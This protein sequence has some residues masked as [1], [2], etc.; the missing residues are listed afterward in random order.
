MSRYQ[1]LRPRRHLRVL[2]VAGLLGALLATA[3]VATN[4]LGVGTRFENLVRRIEIA[5]DPPPDRPSV[6][7]V[8]VTPRPTLS[9]TPPATPSDAPTAPTTSSPTASLT[10]SPTA[11]PTDTP[12]PTPA[13]VAVDVNLLPDAERVFASQ[14]T[15]DWCAPATVQMVLTIFGRGNVSEAFQRELVSR[16]DEWESWQDSHDGG[17]GPSAM[18]E[19]L[20]AY[21][22]TGY[23]IR[24]YETRAD[25]L[26][27]AAGAISDTGSPVVL[28][29]WRG[30]HAWL[31]SGYRADAD[32]R[33]FP[34]ATVSGAYVLDAW[35]PRVSSIWGASDPPGTFQDA[36]EMARNFLPW[37]RPEGKYPE[38]DG[39]FLVLIPTLP[40]AP[41]S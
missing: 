3:T 33:L 26:R 40:F 17:W 14:I 11:A 28:L 4:A 16:I 32:P 19:A 30:A 20:V 22:V 8:L 7:T 36:A 21:G 9:A 10:A 41:G 25:A 12:Q 23:E 24:A 27:D 34:D 5:L 1:S 13:R 18:V 31:M 29:A 39:R 2:L 6:P 38:R 35:Y 15:K 37:K